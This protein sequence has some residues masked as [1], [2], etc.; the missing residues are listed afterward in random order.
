M[1][2]IAVVIP[3]ARYNQFLDQAIF[4]C[5]NL[6]YVTVGVFVN[7]NSSSKEFQ[8]SAYWSSPSVKW[9]YKD[10]PTNN[11]HESFNDAID[12]S[13][14]DW[15]LLLSD[16]DIL[17]TNFLSGIDV[18]NFS[19]KSIFLTRINIIN[20]KNSKIRE[21]R[22]YTS[23]K[24]SRDQAV[25]LFFN[26]S[27]HNHLSLMMFSRSM[28]KNIGKFKNTGYPN[29]YYIDTVFHGI[30]LANSDYVYTS[31]E[32]MLSRR[33]SA[34]QQSS[35]F[36]YGK[37]VSQY[38][39]KIIEA[40]FDDPIFKSEA[41]QRYG[42]ASNFKKQ[43]LR[44]RFFTEWRKLNNQ[45]YNNSFRVRLDFLMKYVLHWNTGI[46]FKLLSLL[47]I[48][49]PPSII[50]YILKIKVSTMKLNNPRFTTTEN[51]Q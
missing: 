22:K 3:T 39:D 35:K 50:A 5:L 4:S 34:F 6:K 15:I 36:Y 25:E 30:A 27:I 17:H 48:S 47:Y 32:I 21:N 11:M 43:M 29:G 38:F 1:H 46:V 42:T 28:Y 23:D 24:Y 2:K 33:E 7:I 40:Y 44:S 31:P 12:H 26:N 20:D 37:E 10:T 8:T 41:L 45:I 18:C 49:V 16:D 19:R 13:T 14:G 9:R 51:D